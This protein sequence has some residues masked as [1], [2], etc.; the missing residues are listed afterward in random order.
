M[1]DY[2]IYEVP[3]QLRGGLKPILRVEHIPFVM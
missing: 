1:R 2:D 3:Y